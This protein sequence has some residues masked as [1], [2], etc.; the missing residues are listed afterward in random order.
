VHTLRSLLKN[1]HAKTSEK[2]A[3]IM[4][5]NLQARMRGLII[6]AL[7]NTTDH[8]MMATSNKSELAVGYSTTYGDMC[9]A[10]SAIGDLYKTKV[11]ELARTIN[12]Q[13]VI[14][15]QSIIDRPPSAELKPKQLD[16]DTLPEYNI[17][18]TILFN[19]IELEKS[20]LEIAHLTKLPQALID[21]VIDMVNI[22]EY[23]RRQGPFCFMVSNKVFGDARRLPIAKRMPKLETV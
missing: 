19:F 20:A 18:D 22:S 10:F 13:E 3:D 4:D 14:I 6:M 2:R 5:Q 15:P 16:T 7:S 9:G 11:W 1:I 23:K 21:K 8:L 17:L 12:R